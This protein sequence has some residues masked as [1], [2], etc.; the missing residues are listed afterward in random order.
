MISP[1][2]FFFF[3]EKSRSPKRLIFCGGSVFANGKRR[4]MRFACPSEL[5]R[6]KARGFTLCGGVQGGRNDSK[7][8]R[9]WLSCPRVC[10][11]TWVHETVDSF[12]GPAGGVV[13]PVLRGRARPLHFVRQRREMLFG[14]P[15]RVTSHARFS[16]TRHRDFLVSFVE[17]CS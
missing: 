11:I 12:R 10:W 9:R 15:Q 5:S 14:A 16:G 8:S 7:L 4:E 1:K 6:T 2:I 13:I 3:L 17:P